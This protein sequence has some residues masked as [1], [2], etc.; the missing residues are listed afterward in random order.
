M[1]HVFLS[2]KREDEPRVSRL[3]QALQAE[4]LDIWWDRGLPGGESWHTHIE[5]KLD[6]AGCVVVVWSASSAGRE[7]AFVRE[8][9]RRGLARNILVPVLIDKLPQLPLGFGEVQAIDLTRWRGAQRD[10]YFQDLLAAIR[11]KLAHQPVPIP[12]GPNKRARKQRWLW[13]GAFGAALFLGALFTFDAFDMA[14][15]TCAIPG[16]QQPRLSDSCGALGL[17][18]RPTKGERV[19]WEARDSGSCQDL[20]EHIEHF[21]DG[22]Y[23]DTAIDMIAARKISFIEDWRPTVRTLTL[24]EPAPE[25]PAKNERAARAIT[26]QRAQA[27]AER[28]CRDFGSGTLFRYVSS[29]AYAD[30]WSCRQDKDGTVCGFEG[31]AECEL[32]ERKQ[33]E[34]EN[35]S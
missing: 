7:G 33:I 6:S 21:P 2:Y 24:F 15:Q 3:A 9:A 23:R 25:S 30:H 35:C 8:E 17:G 14:S 31:Q 19:A 27:D 4:G 18:G 32:T 29:A 22:V 28:L 26:L 12:L 13:G 11:A 10:Q 16:P 34:Q 1:S 20:R 5:E